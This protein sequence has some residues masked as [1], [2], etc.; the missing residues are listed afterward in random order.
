MKKIILRM[1]VIYKKYLS[2]GYGCRFVP[3][4]SEYSFEAINRYGVMRGGWM[5]IKRVSKCH[6]FEDG[7]IDLVE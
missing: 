6:P 1:L 5:A 7:G 3:S 2:K 4:C